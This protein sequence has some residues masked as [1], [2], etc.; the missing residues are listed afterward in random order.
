M[1]LLLLGLLIWNVVHFFPAAARPA[2]GRLIEKVGEQAYT[3]CFALSLIVGILTTVLGWR[4][5][6]LFGGL[7]IWAVLEIVF[8]NRRDGAWKK[9]EAKPGSAVLKP[10]VGAVVV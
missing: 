10:L 4:S 8:L 5:I 2:R 3:G 9:P 1:A 7:L 6:L